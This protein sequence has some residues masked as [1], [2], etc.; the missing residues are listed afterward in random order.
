MG[1]G[2]AAELREDGA[3]RGKPPA[4]YPLSLDFYMV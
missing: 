2:V 4:P 3:E 1:E